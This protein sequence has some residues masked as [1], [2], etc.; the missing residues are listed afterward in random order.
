[1][2]LESENIISLND[3]LPTTDG[4]PSSTLSSNRR[5]ATRELINGPSIALYD[6]KYHPMDDDLHK[7]RARAHRRRSAF[8]QTDKRFDL[9][10]L[11]E[12][13]DLGSDSDNDA[14]DTLSLE[15]GDEDMSLSQI[16]RLNREAKYPGTR[17]SSRHHNKKPLYNLEKH[18]LDKELV[19]LYD[20]EDPHFEDDPRFE[21]DRGPP[22]KRR[23]SSTP[24]ATRSTSKSKTRNEQTKELKAK[25][26]TQP[27][28]KT[29]KLSQ[30]MSSTQAR[31]SP[32]VAYS[33]SSGESE[34]DDDGD[35]VDDDEG[36][37]ASEP[38]L[39]L[40]EAIDVADK[41]LQ[42]DSVQRGDQAHKNEKSDNEQE[43]DTD[44]EVL[45]NLDDEDASPKQ[46]LQPM[47][48]MQVKN[49]TPSDTSSRTVSGGSSVTVC[50]DPKDAD[51]GTRQTDPRSLLTQRDRDKLDDPKEN[52]VPTSTTAAETVNP[53]DLMLNSTNGT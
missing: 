12:K 31:S 34:S 11:D 26:S 16:K 44:E 4:P 19:E 3:H 22:T 52:R 23:K 35:D 39:E 51:G 24:T 10:L 5:Y 38:E 40:D 29:N 32:L 42:A 33:I 17:R 43:H 1:M 21:D 41:A 18:P 53:R 36:Q 13:D 14:S 6:Q 2:G 7:G 45:Q 49:R 8:A 30:L 25:A 15:S 20:G 27:I 48:V 9:V 50:E 37:E 47:A 46:K 28:P